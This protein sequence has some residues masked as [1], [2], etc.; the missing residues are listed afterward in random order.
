M[1]VRL[2]ADANVDGRL[3]LALR[4][5][6]VDIVWA[7]EDGAGR[8]KDPL[9]LDRA[10]E[11]GRVVV[12]GDHYFLSEAARRQ[13]AG[14]SFVG[15]IYYEQQ[16]HPLA[17]LLEDLELVAEAGHPDEMRDSVLWIPL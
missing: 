12:T 10:T 2:Y 8:L 3:I 6:S 14:I 15:V 7:R 4:R 1:S 11:L 5:R 13:A 17:K 16:A 9:I